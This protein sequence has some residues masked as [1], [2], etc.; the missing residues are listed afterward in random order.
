MNLPPLGTLQ[1]DRDVKGW[2]KSEPVSI[3]Y[4]DGQKLQFTIWDLEGDP[5]PQ[6]FS[7]AIT[8]FLRLD[9]LDRRHAADDVYRNF[10][11]TVNA[12]GQDQVDCMIPLSEQVWTHVHPRTLHVGRNPAD[13]KI[14]VMIAAECEWEPEHGL[15]LTYREGKSLHRVS[16][17]DGHIA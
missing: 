13:K 12:V 5:S 4:F 16:E 15:Q 3:P 8:C 10:N 9:S 6:H 2:L 1:P 14:Y 7:D 17:Q 11:N